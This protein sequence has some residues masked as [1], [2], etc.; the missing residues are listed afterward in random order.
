MIYTEFSQN[1]TGEQNIEKK[2]YQE[3]EDSEDNTSDSSK[4]NK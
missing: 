4:D 1:T 3:V 2:E